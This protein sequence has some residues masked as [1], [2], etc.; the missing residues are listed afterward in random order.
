MPEVQ[1]SEQR[2]LEGKSMKKYDIM[3]HE[4]VEVRSIR[5]AVRR[6]RKTIEVRYS[7]LDKEQQAIVHS[8]YTDLVRVIYRDELK[9]AKTPDEI[10]A[11]LEMPGDFIVAKREGK[12][13][14]SCFYGFEGGK[15]VFS[16]KLY[17]AMHFDYESKAREVA[18]S[19]GEGWHAVDTDP[20][21]YEDNKNFLDAIFD[22][23]EEA[24]EEPDE[25]GAD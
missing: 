5:H 12:R 22:W 18:E 2:L 16:K 10:R 4:M 24:E 20:E 7:H 3:G 8:A 15:P 19:L 23:K 6:L 25:G 13:D 17:L 9:A 21:E 1:E 11:I 14:I